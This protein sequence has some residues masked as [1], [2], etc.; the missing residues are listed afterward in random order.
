MPVF[1][2]LDI[3]ALLLAL[4]AVIAMFRFRVGAI[5]TLFACSAAGIALYLANSIR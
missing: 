5:P 4:A 1:E 3:W 2:S